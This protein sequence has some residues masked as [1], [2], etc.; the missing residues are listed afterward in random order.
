MIFQPAFKSIVFSLRLYYWIQYTNNMCGW[1]KVVHKAIFCIFL[2]NI[3]PF[4][5][6]G[7]PGLPLHRGGS[8]HQPGAAGSV[9]GHWLDLAEHFTFWRRSNTSHAVWLWGNI[10]LIIHQPSY[11]IV[12]A[13]QIIIELNITGRSRVCQL[14]CWQRARVWRWSGPRRYPA[15]GVR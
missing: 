15:G 13:N 3:Q 12:I 5:Q 4:E 1:Q 10:E 2:Q 14:P 6:A 11:T 7:R 8:R 9:P